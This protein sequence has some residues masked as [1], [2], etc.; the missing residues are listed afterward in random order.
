MFACDGIPAMCGSQS[1]SFGAALYRRRQ[2]G[3]MPHAHVAKRSDRWRRDLNMEEVAMGDATY[4]D[5]ITEAL[6]R[7]SPRAQQA[8]L[9]PSCSMAIRSAR[10]SSI[11]A[12]R[13]PARISTSA[14]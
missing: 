3:A 8:R 6:P 12:G 11:F 13:M 9:L 14:R 1:R 4:F 10:S 5:L 7:K 2:H